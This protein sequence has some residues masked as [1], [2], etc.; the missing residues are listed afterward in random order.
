MK[1]SLLAV[2]LLLLSAAAPNADEPPMED[3]YDFVT[4]NVIFVLLHEFAHLVLDDFNIPVLG[5]EEDAADSL[6]AVSLIRGDRARPEQDYAYTRMLLMAADANRL[7]WQRGFEKK[8][9]G[10]YLASHPLSV[11]RAA[12]ITCLAYGSNVE[13]LAPLP[14]IVGLP[15]H[16][17]DWCEEEFAAAERAW[18]WVR[19]SYVRKAGQGERHH[20]FSYGEARQPSHQAILDR[21]RES[22]ILERALDSIRDAVFLPEDITLRTLSCGSPNAYWEP[23]DR[24][25]VLCYELVE[26]FYS[27]SAEQGVK[28]LE[29]RIRAI[30]SQGGADP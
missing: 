6:A 3:R 12:R 11:Q 16:R 27:L 4:G 1:H 21:M 8:D 26:G 10:A 14:D 18:T 30:N 20:Q 15:E 24:E 7:L 13:T 17:R 22:R 23:E 28:Q 2:A 5:N 9:I 25:I 29:A 19:D